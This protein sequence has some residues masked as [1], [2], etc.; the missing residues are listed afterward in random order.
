M[1]LRDSWATLVRRWYLVFPALLVAG[2][3]AVGVYSVTPKKYESQAKLLLLP[4]AATAGVDGPGNPYLNLT[5][6]LGMTAD[7]IAVGVTNDATVTRL[8]SLGGTG[9]YKVAADVD[10]NAPVLIITVDSRRPEVVSRTLR[11]VD[12][13]LRSQLNAAQRAAGAPSKTWIS[14]STLMQSP[15]PSPVRK[16]PIQLG[17]ITG[18]G[19]LIVLFAMVFLIDRRYMRVR[20]SSSA[21]TPAQPLVSDPG[22][23]DDDL[24]T[25]Y[26]HRHAASSDQSADE[27]SV[28]RVRS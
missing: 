14:V 13:E 4:P 27:K 22:V 24:L 23:D 2:M 6:G 15:K 25:P 10:V 5:Q 9:A 7:V 20:P 21:Y 26:P 11:L 12:G 17:I 3:L 19:S 1:S 16:T 8:A 18:A 28:A